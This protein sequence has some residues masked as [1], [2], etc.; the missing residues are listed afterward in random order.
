MNSEE[1]SR[2]IKDAYEN[3]K[4]ADKIKS[5]EYIKQNNTEF[6]LK[7]PDGLPVFRPHNLKS[8]EYE[9]SHSRTSGLPVTERIRMN[10]NRK[11]EDC[12]Y[13]FNWRADQHIGY[14]LE[15]FIRR[16]PVIL[17]SGKTSKTKTFLQNYAVVASYNFYTGNIEVN[18][19]TGSDIDSLE[20]IGEIPDSEKFYQD[21]LVF[22]ETENNKRRS[23]PVTITVG[24]WEDLQQQIRK[25]E[26][27]IGE[28]ERDIR[29]NYSR[30]HNSLED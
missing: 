8:F 29:E 13:G 22:K 4:Y 24:T 26:S 18:I 21:Y 2:I 20:Y 15:Q 12:I 17:K 14:I 6:S 19:L 11:R 23:Q 28:L 5:L 3:G 10:R 9:M 1:K 30:I 7:G 27:R 16:E 25:L